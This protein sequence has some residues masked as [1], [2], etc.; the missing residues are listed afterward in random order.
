MTRGM[1]RLARIGEV[2]QDARLDALVCTLPTNVLLLSGYWPVVGT[3]VAVATRGG[4]VAVLAPE[5][6]HALAN[7]GWATDVRPYQPGALSHLTGPAAALG[8]PLRAL[9]HDLGLAEGRIGYEDQESYEQSSYVAMYLFQATLLTALRTAA[10]QASFT[11]AGELIALLRSSLT[12]EELQQVRLACSVA[13]EAF[14]S[15]VRALRPGQSEAAV[16]AAFATPLGVNGLLRPGAERVGGFTFCM[17]GPNSALAGGAYARSR[18]RQLE[19]GDLVLVH[20]NSYL[21]GY[22]TDITRTYC[23]GEPDRRQQ[24]MYQAVFAARAAALDAVRPGAAAVDVDTAA[25]RVLTE[26]GFGNEF[27]HGVGHN[28]G[29]SAISAEY[30]PRLHP[31]SPD[32]LAV[33]MTFNIE[34]A[35]YMKGYGGLRHC[36]VV[37][38]GEKGAEVLTPFQVGMDAMTVA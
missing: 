34:P 2:L 23:L 36:D 26:R 7:Q 35:I 17:S 16:A 25:R 19:A 24:S 21:N 14:A 8:E 5:D 22:W 33:G 28:V 32:R 11:R 12:G 10:P 9:L 29:F 15:G 37:T 6:E 30:P 38:V 1:E 20:C 3:A 27:T 18:S 4:R 13:E 31:A